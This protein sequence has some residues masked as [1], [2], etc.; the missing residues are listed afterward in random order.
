[1][2]TR[3][4]DTS[5]PRPTSPHGRRPSASSRRATSSGTRPGR[6]FA[7]TA[8]RTR[9]CRTSST[10]TCSCSGASRRAA[11]EVSD[12]PRPGP[13]RPRAPDR[14]PTEP[15]SD[16]LR[17]RRARA[18]ERP[19]NVLVDVGIVAGRTHD[20]AEDHPVDTAGPAVG[21]ENLPERS[22][23]LDELDLVALVEKPDLGREQL[24]GTV[25]ETY[26]AVADAP[27]LE[28]GDGSDEPVLERQAEVGAPQPGRAGA[29]SLEQRRPP[30]ARHR[31]ITIQYGRRRDEV[32]GGRVGTT[33]RVGRQDLVGLRRLRLTSALAEQRE[34]HDDGDG[35][36]GRDRRGENAAERREIRAAEDGWQPG[37]RER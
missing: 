37:R 14:S 13:R 6:G 24:V 5:S 18:S 20:L 1:M 35:G 27:A 30:P 10:S 26:D 8:I 31:E 12:G 21:A 19:Q 29:G 7:R 28:A 33:T 36:C 17:R 4:A 22:R 2:R 3:T 9:S 11:R 16:A 23:P 34:G 25:E 32:G 15:R